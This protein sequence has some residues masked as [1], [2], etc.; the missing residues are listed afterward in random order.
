[1]LTVIVKTAR[2]PR[3]VSTRDRVWIRLPD[4]TDAVLARVE[5]PITLEG[6]QVTVDDVTLPVIIFSFVRN[7]DIVDGVPQLPAAEAGIPFWC[8]NPV[9]PWTDAAAE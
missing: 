4:T 3:G 1:M 5:G 8:L 7:A 9:R 6:F 2:G